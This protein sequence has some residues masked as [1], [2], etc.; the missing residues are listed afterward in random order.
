[1]R[2][3]RSANDVTLIQTFT[4]AMVQDGGYSSVLGFF[5]MTASSRRWPGIREQLNK[6]RE[7]ISRPALRA[8]GHHATG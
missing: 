1:M 5:S 4:E 3:R 7:A 8:V 2:P 6:V